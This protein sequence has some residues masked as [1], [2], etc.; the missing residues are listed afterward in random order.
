MTATRPDRVL[1]VCAGLFLASTALGAAFLFAGEHMPVVATMLAQGVVYAFSAWWVV[2]RGAAT[3]RRSALLV[4][5]GA[6]VVARAMLLPMPTVSTDIFRYVWD[7][8]VQAAGINPYSH[9]PADPALAP[10][11]DAT[12]FP[13]INRAETAVTIY[14]P[15]AQIVF[16]AVTRLGESVAV[17]KA[18]MV[19][20]E[21]LI[22]FALLRLLAARGLPASL[23]LLYLWHPLP[24]FEFAGSGHVDAVGIGFM[25]LAM[26][27]ADRGRPF[28]AGM[29]LAAGAAAKYVPVAVAPALYRRWD[30]RMPAGFALALS[31]LYLPYLGAGRGVLGFL[32]GYVQEEGIGDGGIIWLAL[33][34]R[35]GMLPGWASGTYLA[36][37]GLVLVGFGL[38]VVM[39][40][41]PDRISPEAA[42]GLLAGFLVLMAPHYA[43]YFTW[44]VPLLCFRPS[45]AILWLT[46]AAPLVYG[47]LW[48]WDRSAS[49]VLLYCPFLLILLIEAFRSNALAKESGHASRLGQPSVG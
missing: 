6:A 28:L 26:L 39:R 21:G 19:A 20:F 40:R 43:W 3:D 15:A 5:V 47:L 14:P 48:P 13:H 42:L 12:I 36:L 17:M 46:V 30:W 16:L 38:A 22:A 27:M 35:L 31:V 8:R 41:R 2:S 4:I 33:L 44:L 24:L 29:L 7:G 45:V 25:M 32:P 9:R 11:R 49:E 1:W 18:A 23:V 34:A 10:L 37:A